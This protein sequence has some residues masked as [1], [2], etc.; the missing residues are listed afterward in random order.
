M[1]QILDFFNRY[2][3]IYSY[4]LNCAVLSN[5]RSSFRRCVRT[6]KFPAISG[7][8]SCPG[9]QVRHSW[10]SAFDR[11]FRVRWR[12]FPE[13]RVL[14]D[15]NGRLIATRGLV[16]LESPIAP[17]AIHLLTSTMMFTGSF[18]SHR[19]PL[20]PYYLRRCRLAHRVGWRVR[21]LWKSPPKLF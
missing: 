13:K 6:I 14:L 4:V 2:I 21:M 16:P 11:T 1:N 12:S 19:S 18:H 17:K 10:A 20:H 9:T 7:T 8:S 3:H 5:R 15:S